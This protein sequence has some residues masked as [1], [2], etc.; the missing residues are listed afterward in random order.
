MTAPDATIVVRCTDSSHESRPWTIATFHRA[1]GQWFLRGN[2]RDTGPVG[3]ARPDESHVYLD[4]PHTRTDARRSGG[5]APENWPGRARYSLICKTCGLA[6]DVR[7]EN[8][9][10]VLTKLADA[11]VLNVVLSSLVRILT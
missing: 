1:G 11:G 4:G 2:A 6:L 10:P 3:M 7:G 5:P 8:L 9:D